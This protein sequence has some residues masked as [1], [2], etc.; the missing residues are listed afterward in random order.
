M[1]G[2][3]C[4]T[5]IHFARDNNDLTSQT[6]RCRRFPPSPFPMMNQQGQM[7]IIS[8]YPPVVKDWNCGEHDSKSEPPSLS[9]LTDDVQH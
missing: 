2:L 3:Q 9:A 8:E 7:Q 6:G 1:I 5:C 4:R